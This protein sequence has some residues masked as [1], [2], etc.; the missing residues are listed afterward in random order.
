MEDVSQGSVAG[1]KVI[2]ERHGGLVETELNVR[3]D[4]FA[5]MASTWLSSGTIAQRGGTQRVQ[6]H[7][8]QCM[9]SKTSTNKIANDQLIVLHT[10][11]S[12][13]VATT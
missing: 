4:G 7:R 2:Y 10:F 1:S 13:M 5:Q 8:D 3:D 11:T 6:S 9:C 12:M